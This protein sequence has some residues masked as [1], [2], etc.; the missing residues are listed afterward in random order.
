MPVK[1]LAAQWLAGG[2]GIGVLVLIGEPFCEQAG[3][4]EGRSVQQ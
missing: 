3:V 4:S 1:W 2:G